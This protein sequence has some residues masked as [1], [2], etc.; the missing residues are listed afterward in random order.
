MVCA[1]L[2][3]RKTQTRR[4]LRDPQP[5]YV[6]GNDLWVKERWDVAATSAAPDVLVRYPAD[7]AMRAVNGVSASWRAPARSGRGELTP[8]FMPRWASRI[9]LTVTGV[10]RERVQ[11]ISPED[12][13]AEGIA[14]SP[15]TPPLEAWRTQWTTLHGATSWDAN[16]EVWVVTFC[17]ARISP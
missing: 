15:S 4:L 14:V 12:I 17:V 1:L 2:A 10:R 16:P 8:L 9:D 11:A 3:G 6:T 5:P 13:A 7:N